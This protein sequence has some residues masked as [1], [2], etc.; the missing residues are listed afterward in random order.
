[1]HFEFES[2]V[3]DST[4]RI[5]EETQLGK[6]EALIELKVAKIRDAFE[7]MDTLARVEYADVTS[8][9]DAHKKL[10]LLCDLN[11]PSIAHEIL[12]AKNLLLE[13]RL[14]TQKSGAD[15]LRRPIT[16]QKI[17][18]SLAENFGRQLSDLEDRL[19][20]GI[21]AESLASQKSRA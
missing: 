7:K 3:R 4:A 13:L 6:L 10:R 14:A 19:I 17:E 9:E 15:V 1:M 5:A 20:A 18:S 8:T 11:K 2:T 21:E 16:E 12:D